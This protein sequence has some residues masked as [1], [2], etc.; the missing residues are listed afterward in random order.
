MA[1]RDS[2]L[3][4]ARVPSELLITSIGTSM[5]GLVD[6]ALPD[7][8][9][10]KGGR[11]LL[12]WTTREFSGQAATGHVARLI[13]AI[14]AWNTFSGACA[15]GLD[16]ITWAAERIMIGE[17][18]AA[19]AGATETPLSPS[20]L[21]SFRASGL[22]SEWSGPPSEASRPFD[23][24]HSGLVVA[25]GAGIVILED[26]DWAQARGVTA[27][28]R[29]LGFGS[30]TEGTSG[31]PV[32]RNADST[33]RSVALALARAGLQASDIDFVCAHG[34]S[35]PEHDIA[36]TIG[37]RRALA[38]HAYNVPVS[39]LKSMCGQ[40][41]A[42]S[43]AIQVVTSCLV[44]K[45]QLIPPTINHWEPDTDCDLDYVP[46]VARAARVRH[47]LIHVRSI[48]GSHASMILG[49]AI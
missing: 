44:L 36:E 41:F 19:V 33:A 29:V 24:A 27:Y 43:S 2:E 39:S 30:A 5:S 34:N 28:A 3:D 16:A 7:F 18:R 1:I 17:A 22:L 47:I 15:A 9:A 26:A 11:N 31:K 8:E 37:F 10:F 45:H 40:A 35:I 6:V 42:A 12:S 14:G 21:E 20:T 23:R 38:K 46:R 25:E 13:N 48:G 4:R 49:P 32:E